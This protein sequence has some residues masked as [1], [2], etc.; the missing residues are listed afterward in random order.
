M[1][2]LTLPLIDAGQYLRPEHSNLSMIQ[3]TFIID[4]IKKIIFYFGHVYKIIVF[5]LHLHLLR[6]DTMISLIKYCQ[7]DKGYSISLMGVMGCMS[8]LTF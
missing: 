5:S 6:Y 8:S 4:R 2:P 3:I 7:P 1:V